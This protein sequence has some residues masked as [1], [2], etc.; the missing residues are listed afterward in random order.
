[1]TPEQELL[2]LKFENAQLKAENAQIR[3]QLAASEATLAQLVGRLQ[4]LEARLAQD[5]HNSSK[6]PSSDGFVRSPKKRS[7]RKPSGKKPGGQPGHD[8]HALS[9][10]ENPDQVVAHLPLNCSNCQADLTN[11]P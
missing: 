4:E 11:L 1:M 3:E 10:V 5:S 9:Q 2:Q 6:P 8:G 7:L